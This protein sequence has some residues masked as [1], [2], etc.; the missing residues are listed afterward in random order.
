[1]GQGYIMELRF[2]QVQWQGGVFGF[3]ALLPYAKLSV[4][5]GTSGTVIA[6]DSITGFSGNLLDLKVASTT[7][8]SVNQAGDLLATG[9]TTL[10]N[11][12]AVN[13]TSTN[14]TSTNFFSTT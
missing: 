6:V 14:A 11:F 4:V 13:S 3:G 8:F 1:M 2:L 12:T 5:G 7:K 9:S 10:Q